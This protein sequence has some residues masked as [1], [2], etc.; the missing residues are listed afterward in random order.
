[1]NCCRLFALALTLTV[2]SCSSTEYVNHIDMFDGKNTCYEVNQRSFLYSLNQCT[3]KLINCSGIQAYGVQ[4]KFTDLKN[5]YAPSN[6]AELIKNKKLWEYRIDKAALVGG[7]SR[8]KFLGSV[9]PKT[10]IKI[11]GAY[12]VNDS[13][14]GN[15]WYVLAKIVD[16]EHVGKTIELSS[17]YHLLPPA[18]VN[19]SSKSEA[20]VINDNFLSYCSSD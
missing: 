1:M 18:W 15:F 6:E 9:E 20:P 5:R 11:T 2:V 8:S 16:G 10:K 13:T 3:S 4:D 17:P 7:S 14:I 19:R 12:Y